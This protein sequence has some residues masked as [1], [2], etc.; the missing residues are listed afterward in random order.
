MVFTVAFFIPALTLYVQYTNPELLKKNDLH[1]LLLQKLLHSCDFIR[2]SS[3][4]QYELSLLA[5]TNNTTPLLAS[6]Q[7]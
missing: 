1:H 5:Y 6:H 7:W 4:K 2:S 3:I